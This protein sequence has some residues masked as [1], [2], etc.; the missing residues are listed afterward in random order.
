MNSLGLLALIL[1]IISIVVTIKYVNSYNNLD[2]NLDKISKN[3]QNK[4]SLSEIIKLQDLFDLSDK[5]IS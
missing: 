3:C 5:E 2:K 4:S 1:G